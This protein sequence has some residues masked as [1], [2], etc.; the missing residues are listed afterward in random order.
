MVAKW[1]LGRAGKSGQILRTYI[2]FL[3]SEK[4]GLENFISRHET[5]LRTTLGTYCWLDLVIA[6]ADLEGG[7]RDASPHQQH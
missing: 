2:L 6:R 5:P 4:A 7:C 1:L 3:L